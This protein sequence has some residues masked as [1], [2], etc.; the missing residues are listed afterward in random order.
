MERSD[1]IDVFWSKVSHPS[2]YACWEWT[3]GKNGGG[4]GSFWFNGKTKSAHSVAYELFYGPILEG[5]EPDHL[6]RN[7][8]CVNPLHLE[9]VTRKENIRR[10]AGHGGVLH[11]HTPKTH[12]LRGHERTPDNLDSGGNCKICLVEWG[13]KY[14][15]THKEKLAEYS[16]RYR[17]AHKV[18]RAEYSR[19]YR[20]E[21]REEVVE[22]ERTYRKANREK[23]NA[24]KRAHY[25]EEKK[26]L[27]VT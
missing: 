16:R 12:C 21:H 13:K 9:A 3:A 2:L 18:E 20:A 25:K 1:R 17:A 26:R 23:I 5:L 14:H 10:G 7:T 15:A 22:R 6:C 27:Q 4:Y 11:T 8:S 19:V 24:K